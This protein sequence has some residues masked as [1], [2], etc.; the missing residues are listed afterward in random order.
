MIRSQFQF[1]LT[2]ILGR[3]WKFFLLTSI[4]F[5]NF[6]RLKRSLLEEQHKAEMIKT[7]ANARYT[8]F[9]ANKA[10]FIASSLSKTRRSIVLDRVMHTD[11]SDTVSLITDPS[12]IKAIANSHYQSVAGAPPIQRLT[13]DDMSPYWQS[14][15]H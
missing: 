10:A 7:Y 9:A 6:P 1:S 15:Y 13:V 11:H 4:R 5:V 14:I 8:N 2:D 12:K 3:N